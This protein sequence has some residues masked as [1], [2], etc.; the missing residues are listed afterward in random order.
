MTEGKYGFETLA[1][2]AGAAPDPTTGA[3]AVP[4]YQTTSYVFDDVDHAAS[5]F[6]LQK[7]GNIYSAADQPDRLGAGGADRGARGRH[8]RLRHGVG[9]RRPVPHLPQPDEP[10]RQYRLVEQA[11]WRLDQPDEADLPAVRLARRVTSTRA[12]PQNFAKAIDATDQGR[13]HRER[14]EPRRHHRRHRGDRQRSRTSRRAADR[15]QHLAR[16]PISAGRSSG[17]P[18][19]SSTR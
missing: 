15:R 3:R 6:N 11:V 10:R 14:V 17:A 2:H 18:T 8:G 7:F 13:L 9:P 4:I 16:R 5:L 1:I 12:S 19:S